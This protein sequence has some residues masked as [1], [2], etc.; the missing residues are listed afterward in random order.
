MRIDEPTAREAIQVSEHGDLPN[1]R[2][3]I[4]LREAIKEARRSIRESRDVVAVGRAGAAAYLDTWTGRNIAMYLNSPSGR[5]AAA[6]A[7]Q[8]AEMQRDL[9]PSI[10]AAQ[11]AQ[12][13][14]AGIGQQMSWD[15][16]DAL[17]S[18][19]ENESEP[20][21]STPVMWVQPL[22]DRHAEL[23]RKFEDS[24]EENRELRE[25]VVQSLLREV[26]R[27]LKA[28]DHEA[29]EPAARLLVQQRPDRAEP[30]LV[31]GVILNGQGKHAEA[32]VIFEQAVRIDPDCFASEQGYRYWLVYEAS[33]NG[34]IWKPRDEKP[35]SES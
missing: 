13:D 4:L 8:A 11:D 10:Q 35:E 25:Q 1:L 33:L 23:E 2:D 32:C 16:G 15:I 19:L 24:S 3:R 9:G 20:P 18:A 27:A 7:K 29:A 12:K 28:G 17:A 30:L 5:T 26:V 34:Q 21:M 14:F 22:R 31:L 6:A